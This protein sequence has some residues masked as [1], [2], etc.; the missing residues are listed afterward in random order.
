MTA[1]W[2]SVPLPD[3][4]RRLPKDSAGRPVPRFV[5]W[6]DGVPDFRVMSFDHLRLAVRLKLCWVCAQPLGANATFTI[7]PMC[8]VN[9]VSAEPPSH[10]D[11]A[12]YSALACPFLSNP[13]RV[14]REAHIPDGAVVPAGISIPRNPGVALLWTT[15]SWKVEPEGRGVLFRLGDPTRVEW[16]AEGREAT[17]AEV[18]ASIET[19]L[20]TLQEMATQEG[21]R[22]VAALETQVADAL[23]LV[24][25]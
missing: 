7:G 15:R 10:L 11:C 22:A 23:E 8:A 2:R 21:Q 6:I 20:P 4:M 16:Y 14:R 24:P 13:A 1:D 19:G 18:M 12:T 17:R 3:R 25:A 9:R 5:E